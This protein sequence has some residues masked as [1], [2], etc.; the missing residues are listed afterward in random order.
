LHALL[1]PQADARHV[2]INT[3]LS[4]NLPVVETDPGK[5]Q[6]ILYNFLSNAMKFSPENAIVTVAAERITR[7]DGTHGVRIGVSDQGPGIPYDMQDIIFEKFRQVDASH[8]RAHK[9]VGLGL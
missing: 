6:Q 5:L 4:P 7:P 9:G 1:R 3:R 2:S 8:T